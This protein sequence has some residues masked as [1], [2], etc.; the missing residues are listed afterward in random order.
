MLRARVTNGDRKVANTRFEVLAGTKWT[1]SEGPESLAAWRERG[2]A[3]QNRC[4]NRSTRM[5]NMGSIGRVCVRGRTFQPSYL[6]KPLGRNPCGTH[7][8]QGIPWGANAEVTSAR[9][10]RKTGN[11]LEIT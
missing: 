2:E 9:G 6:A 11:C 3:G 5:L 7:T 8:V 4:Y 10:N 1:H